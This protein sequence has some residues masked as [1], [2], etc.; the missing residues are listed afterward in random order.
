MKELLTELRKEHN[1]TLKQ[2]GEIIGVKG[3]HDAWNRINRG[4]ITVVQMIKLK[5]TLCKNNKQR[6]EFEDKLK[7]LIK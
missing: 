6:K 5:E 2:F 7:N 4:T 3:R 1:L